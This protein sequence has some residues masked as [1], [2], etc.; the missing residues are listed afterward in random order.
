MI[1][2]GIRSLFRLARFGRAPDAD[3]EEEIR[4]H[5]EMR[6]QELMRQGFSAGDANAEALRRF[7]PLGDA[8]RELQRAANQREQSMRF[9]EWMESLVQDM[10]YALRG[11]RREPAFTACVVG[12]LALGIGANAAM[13]GVVDRLLLRGPEYVQHPSRLARFYIK[14]QPRGMKEQQEGTFGYVMYD[15][16]KKSTAS[17]AGVSAYASRSN[18]VTMGHGVDARLLALGKSTADLFPLLGVRAL[19]G[20]F[21]T[22]AEDNTSSPEHVVAIGYGLWQR[23]FGGTDDVLGKTIVLG[24][25]P[26]RII[27]VA[28][29]GFTGPELAPV[30]IWMPLSIQGRSITMDWTH[31][32]NWQALAVIA[33]LKPGVTA[34][35]AGSD[36]TLAYRRAYTGGDSAEAIGTMGL[37]PIAYDRDGFEPAEVMVSRWLI[38]VSAIVLLI[39]CSNV[40]NLLLARAVRRRREVAVRLALGAGRG[41]LMRLLLIEGLLLAVA[42]GVA[43]LLVAL[44]T[45]GFVRSTLLPNVEWTSS[46]V[47]FR[48]LALSAT[49]SIFIGIAVALVPALQ[50]SKPNLTS[51][52]KSGVRDGGG[53]GLKL[54]AALT[55]VQAA[56]SVVLL[57][58]AGL[59][60]TSLHRVRTLD[61]GIQP[62]RALVVDIGWRRA[63]TITDST[64]RAVEIARRAN[65]FPAALTRVRGLTGVERAS[66]TVGLPFGNRFSQGMRVQGMDSTPRIGGQEPGVSAVGKDYFETVGTRILRGR[67]FTAADRAGSEPVVI[68]SAL[69]AA[70]AW[71]GQDP[72]G[73]CVYTG[74]DRTL[75][76]MP[77]ARVVGVSA[78]TKR[79][80]LREKPSMHYYVPIGQE[81]GFGGTELLVR[82]RGD[83]AT[84]AE[85]IRRELTELDP[86]ISLVA[87]TML[88]DA[89]DLQSRPWTL[90]ASMFSLMGVLALIVAAIGLYSVMSYLIAQRT[91]EIGVRVA[92]GAQGR[93]IV[94][95]VV[96][97]SLGMAMLGVVL[98]LGLSLAGGHFLGPLLFDTS[99]NNPIVLTGV[100]AAL[101]LVAL[102]ATIVPA[103]RA[104]RVDAML[105]L[106]TE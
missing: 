5:L 89:I 42:G 9:T 8:R 65:F 3:I 15:I 58:G 45:G 100:A 99:P 20:R 28:P 49:V 73:K 79:S 7:G 98:G 87:T 68:V 36:A 17:F 27:G 103:L 64:A 104:K 48:V 32:W 85:Q 76:K 84:V 41:R 35:Q 50:A 10:R 69:L 13:F 101:I 95:L 94:A 4:A 90:G 26:Y 102:L 61:L 34:E 88:Q 40:I 82:P 31:S 74:E 11:L 62:D 63:S 6:A 47:D 93:D 16:M 54:R 46:V 75:D 71:P 22:E 1:R 86:S 23:E 18:G 29:K 97:N 53:H 39:A 56:L 60:V 19:R 14:V 43:G 70:T 33:R 81:T 78:D 2:P 105:A 59:F 25:E 67:A 92:L 80:S 91:H 66:L 55:V 83:P 77:C 38:G 72:M 96:R 37:A 106:R 12:T 44:I 52:L 57:V 21:F 24:D 30:D 51:A